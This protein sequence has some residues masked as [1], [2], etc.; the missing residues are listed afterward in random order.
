MFSK[1]VVKKDVKDE[2]YWNRIKKV[3]N[4]KMKKDIEIEPGDIE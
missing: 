3:V 4:K 2:D 1:W